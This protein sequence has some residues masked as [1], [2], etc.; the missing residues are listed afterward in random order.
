MKAFEEANGIKV[1]YEIVGQRPGEIAECYADASKAE[2]ELGWKASGD[3]CELKVVYI[4]GGYIGMNIEFI[5][6]TKDDAQ[7]ICSLFTND[8]YEQI[9]AENHTSVE[10]WEKRF[11]LFKDRYNYIVVDMNNNEKIGWLM[12]EV[13]RDRCFLHL[14]V[15][16]YNLLRKSYG[17]QIIK[18]MEQSIVHQA[19]CI[20]LDVQQKNICAVNFYKRNGFHI[21]G[22]EKQPVGNS[23]ELYY[24]MRKNLG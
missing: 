22:E 14:V 16:Q 19:D 17:S 8:E 15:L 5:K 2:R 21:V 12:Y 9:F 10:E 3:Y 1:K 20:E 4:L 7:F 6:A 11:D 24:K 13:N 23:E 18:K